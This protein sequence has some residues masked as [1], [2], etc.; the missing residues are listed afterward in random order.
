MEGCDGDAA[1]AGRGDCA[2]AAAAAASR[3][4]RVSDPAPSETICF[5]CADEDDDV[6]AAGPVS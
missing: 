4:Q 3:N 1:A 5:F 2:V 6:D